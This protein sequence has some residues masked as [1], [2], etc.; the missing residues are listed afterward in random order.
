MG[1]APLSATSTRKV[2]FEPESVQ[3]GES[4][5]KAHDLSENS[6][7]DA[8]EDICNQIRTIENGIAKNSADKVKRISISGIGANQ[9]KP[10]FLIET[11]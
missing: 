6:L 11:L 8:E 2:S 7:E 5:K 4:D 9:G 3:K 1:E 10:R